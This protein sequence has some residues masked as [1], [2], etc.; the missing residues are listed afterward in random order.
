[1]FMLLKTSYFR[2]IQTYKNNNI[3]TGEMSVNTQT[4]GLKR[5][6]I[7]K[8]YTNPYVVTKC[9]QKRKCNI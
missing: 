2:A 3:V 7:D 8:Y 5:N 6:T 4:I 1:M 9:I